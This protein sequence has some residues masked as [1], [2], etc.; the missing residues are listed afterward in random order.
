MSPGEIEQLH[1]GGFGGYGTD[2]I[3]RFAL[4]AA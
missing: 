2:G 4:T 3:H 1:L